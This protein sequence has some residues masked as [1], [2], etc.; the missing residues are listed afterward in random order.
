M[1]PAARRAS[2]VGRGQGRAGQGSRRGSD[3]AGHARH[4]AAGEAL[5]AWARQVS[6]P[7]G[8]PCQAAWHAGEGNPTRGE[9]GGQGI[10][11]AQAGA[12]RQAL[13]RSLAGEAHGDRPDL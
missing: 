12:R 10:I 7:E 5:Q 9:G 8:L 1:A 3:R 11:F 6:P 13:N 4:A 2:A